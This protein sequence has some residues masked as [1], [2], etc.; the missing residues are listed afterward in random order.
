MVWYLV[1]HRGNFTFTPLTTHV[2]IPNIAPRLLAFSQVPT[3]HVPHFQAGTLRSHRAHDDHWE[4][5]INTRGDKTLSHFWDPWLH[6]QY[7]ITSDKTMLWPLVGPLHFGKCVSKQTAA[8]KQ[9][10]PF[11]KFIMTLLRRCINCIKRE[12]IG[13]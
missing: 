3:R 6:S 2:K 4:P 12:L 11:F 1:K 8:M 13:S 10:V 5:C 9:K 7:Q